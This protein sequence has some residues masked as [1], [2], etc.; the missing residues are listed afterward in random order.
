MLLRARGARVRSSATRSG[1]SSSA[2]RDEM[3]ARRAR[4][5]LE[6]G[7]GV[8]ACVGE[9]LEQRESGDTELVLKIQVEAIAFAAGEH[10]DL[11][12][13][14][15]PVWAIGTGKTATPEHG[16]GGARVHQGAARPAGA[17]RRLGQAGERRRAARRS[18]RR[19]R[20]R[21]RRLA[22]PRLLRSD[23]PRPRR[24][25]NAR[26]SS[27]A[28]AA[29]RPGPATRSSS[30]E[31][32][33]FDRLWRD[34]PAH[35][36]RRPRA[37]RSACRRGQMGNSEVGHLTIGSGRILFQ[38]LQRVNVADPRR[39]ASSRT[40]RS[41]APSSGRAS[42]AATCTC[43]GSSRT[44][45]STRTSTTCRRCSSSPRRQGWRSAPGS[46]RSRTA[47]TSRR[48]RPSPISPSCRPSGSRPSSAATT[49]WTAT[50]AGSGRRR[51]F[52]AIVAAHGHARADSA[53]RRPCKRATTPASPTS[54]SSRSCV[55][56][57]PRARAGRRGDLLQLPPR[58]RPPA[59][60]Q[61]RSTA[62]FDLTTMTRYCDDF[63]VPGRVRRA[64]GAARR[65]PRRSPRAAPASSTSRRPR[66]TRTSRTSSTAASRTSGRARRGSS[67]RARA[68]SPSYDH[69]PEMSAREV[70]A[71]FAAEIGDGYRFAV[72]QL[73]EPGH[74][75]AHGLDPGRDDRG[76]GRRTS[77]SASSSRR[78]TR[79][80]GVCLVTA[81]H[82]N[83]EADARAGRRQPA[84]GAHDESRAARPHL[85]SSAAKG[86]GRTLRSSAYGPAAP[87]FGHTVR[88]DGRRLVRY[89]EIGSS[90]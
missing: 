77:A 81:D 61:A 36:A 78:R 6:A 41:S 82:G 45:A 43:S 71:R 27:T 32:P 49:R 84:H 46:T 18:R 62:G 37:R 24:P 73:R 88:D 72:D 69:K 86:R 70:A 28:G 34:V 30:R 11:V 60:A 66:S 29:R 68:T 51:A 23:L 76:R 15:E 20:A 54:S 17:L 31:T 55:D 57:A 90:I 7:L 64:G 38:D 80:G 12:I 21:R 56:G 14:Y 22:R 65:S 50:S 48:R 2:R 87:G 42:A 1:G 52:D 85:E 33:V 74:G 75:R 25:R 5:A 19:R 8:I 63:D 13:A 89:G 67:S 53:A 26:R 9:T 3:V 10:D 35:D 4:T 16:G 59:R 79:A 58:P 47:A 40:R 44:A 83:A 39:L